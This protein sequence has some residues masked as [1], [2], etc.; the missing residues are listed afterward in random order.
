MNTKKS[1]VAYISFVAAVITAFVL[2]FTFTALSG[3]DKE[4]YSVDYNRVLEIDDY[5]VKI[6]DVIYLSDLN[7]VTFTF[8][9]KERFSGADG[10][11]PEVVA[12]NTNISY[13]SGKAFWIEETK[14]DYKYYVVDDIEDDFT[15]LSIDFVTKEADR[16]MPDT[17]DEFGDLVKGETIKG[18]TFRQYV[19]IDRKDISVMTAA[20]KSTMVTTKARITAAPSSRN[21]TAAEAV[22]AETVTVTASKTEDLTSKKST[23]TTK[24]VTTTKKKTTTSKAATTTKA[25]I[26]API[27]TTTTAPRITTTVATTTAAAKTTV[28]ST[29]PSVIHVNAIRLNV[30]V[31]GGN[32]KLSSGGK[33]KI[34][35]V[36]EPINAADKSVIWTSNRPDIATVDRS[37]NIAAVSKGKAIITATTNDGGLSASCMVTVE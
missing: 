26:T 15:Y 28:K 4:S 9:F 1:N 5:Y 21:T 19:R 7:Q 25:T 16:V 24:V 12:V 35:A 14:S 22:N 31:S 32:I 17:V 2:I 20:E 13:K 10:S 33:Y 34:S 8:N 29:K 37:G 3:N 36:V 18:E 30:G 27:T 23:T 6:S 11:E